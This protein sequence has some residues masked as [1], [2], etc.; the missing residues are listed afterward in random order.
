MVF[1]V[2]T[3]ALR[4]TAVK[5]FSNPGANLALAWAN[6]EVCQ[7]I[8]RGGDAHA[9]RLWLCTK[10]GSVGDLTQALDEARSRG[11]EVNPEFNG[12]RIA[13]TLPSSS[14]SKLVQEAIL[15]AEIRQNNIPTTDSGAPF[16]ILS[17]PPSL[18]SYGKDD[19]D[20]SGVQCMGDG[21]IS[22]D[23]QVVS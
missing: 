4:G 16:G 8:A 17:P 13:L 6:L 10:F 21:G 19:T 18:W 1:G 14:H 2:V 20:V 11:L 22:P 3:G 9:A 5:L 15:C 12:T 7:H 23:D